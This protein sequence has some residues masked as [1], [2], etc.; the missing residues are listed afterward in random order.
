[1][2]TLVDGGTI[3]SANQL[4]LPAQVTEGGFGDRRRIVT[5]SGNGVQIDVVKKAEDEDCL[6]VRL[7]EC[8]G[9]REKITLASEYPVKRIVP[10][11]LLEHDCGEA[12][13][14]SKVEFVAKPFEIRTFKLYL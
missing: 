10:C 9:G 7:H 3:E 6:I 8:R 11:N 1:M 4:N 5:V 2:E 13:E 14:G 12:V